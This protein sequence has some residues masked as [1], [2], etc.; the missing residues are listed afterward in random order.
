MK[1]TKILLL[2][3]MTTSI[4]NAQTIASGSKS[5]RQKTD[6]WRHS[7]ENLSS[8]PQKYADF[9]KKLADKTGINYTLDASFLPQRV[10]P[11]GKKTAWQSQYY[12]TIGWNMFSSDTWGSG[13]LQSAYTAVRYW[14]ANG[15]DLSNQIGVLNPINDYSE[16]SNYFDQLSYTH[17][18]AGKANILSVTIGQFPMYLFDG[19]DYNSNQQIN[20]LNEALSQ[21]ATS[22]YPSASLGAYATLTPNEQISVSFGAQNANNISGE[23][24]SWNKM[25]KGKFTEFVSATWTPTF[26]GQPGQYSVLLYNQPDTDEQ[27]LTSRGWSINLQQNITDKIALFGRINGVGQSAGFAKQ[28]YVFGGVY[29]NPFNRNELDQI[30]LATAFNKLNQDI[31]GP[32]TRSWENVIEGY[33][34]FGISNFMTLTPDFQFYIN[35]GADLNRNTAFATSLRATL[36]F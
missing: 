30:G 1:T 19:G 3:L 20:F 26:F 31:N 17:T 5:T 2:L 22:N 23:T 12:G 33:Y 25:K 4:A 11:N 16:N 21:N 13:M 18:F 36:M 7:W 8:L 9:K 29:N 10:S 28:S 34:A 35:P 24:I 14:G 32:G 15:N 6:V 27:E